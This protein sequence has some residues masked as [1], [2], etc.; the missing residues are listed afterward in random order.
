MK[1]IIPAGGYGTRL[2]PLTYTKPKVILPLASSF[3]LKTILEHVSKF[4]LID[5]VIIST[6]KNFHII[7]EKLGNS[8]NGLRLTY[9]WEDKR[10]GGV[11]CIKSASKN[12]KDT[13]IVYLGDNLS[14][15]DFNEL[16]KFHEE[17]KADA[18]LL[19][20]KSNTPW[21]Y[22]VALTDESGLIKRFIEKPKKSMFQEAYISTGIYV[23]NSNSLENI[24]EDEF[25]DNTGEIFPRIM[26]EGKKV[27]GFKSGC[28][29]VDVGSIDNYIQANEWFLN[30]KYQKPQFIQGVDIKSPIYI[31]DTVKLKQHSTIGPNSIILNNSEIDS[32]VKII[33]SIIFEN[34]Y[35]K[36]DCV[37]KNSVISENCEIG[38]GT[39]INRSIIGGASI[40]EDE[41]IIESS[42]I[43]PKM[44]I[45]S[46]SKIEGV[47]KHQYVDIK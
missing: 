22:G 6:N 46:K 32:N 37:I 11:A 4:N 23:F 15:V 33:N 27:Y 24:K 1:M 47:I 8:F 14:D 20:V 21:L 12:I 38:Q 35:I 42:K 3:I 36:N 25:I 44:K 30:L 43:W 13:F 29:W 41:C 9:I 40:L 18:T 19:L 31:S 2:R 28:Y 26:S 39:V 17:K 7:K 5:E 45:L 10:L 16:I 34:V